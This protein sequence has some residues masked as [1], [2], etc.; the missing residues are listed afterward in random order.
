MPISMTFVPR[1][2]AIPFKSR[3]DSFL[4]TSSWPVNTVNCVQC[5]RCVTGMPA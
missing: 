4:F 3:E 2:S 5:L 1:A